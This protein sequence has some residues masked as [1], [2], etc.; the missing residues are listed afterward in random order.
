MR[1]GERIEVVVTGGVASVEE[2][3]HGGSS[4]WSGRAGAQ[5]CADLRS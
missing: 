2:P 4:G 5:R 3:G 1:V